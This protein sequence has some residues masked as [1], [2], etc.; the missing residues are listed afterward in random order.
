MANV[1]GKKALAVVVLGCLCAATI[2]LPAY[3]Q[4]HVQGEAS[5]ASDSKGVIEV[6]YTVDA[7]AAGRRAHRAAHRA[8]RQHGSRMP[9]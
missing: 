8:R 1:R 4:Y 9:G 6:T 5:A 7:T 2:A 3:A